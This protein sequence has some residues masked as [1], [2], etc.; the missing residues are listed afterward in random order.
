MNNSTYKHKEITDKII[1]SFYEVY[2]EL[3]HGF[4]ESI[5]ERALYIVLKSQDMN[6]ERQKDITVYFR[7]HIVGE[8]RVDMIVAEKVI[9]EIKAVRELAPE[10]KAQLI[11]YLKATDIEVGLLINFGQRPEIKRFI[12]DNK[13]KIIC[14]DLCKSVAIEEK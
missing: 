14:D 13:R 12:F 3:G 10:H 8:L 1:K 2:N 4:L 6:V 11:N 9:V 7:E 5:Y